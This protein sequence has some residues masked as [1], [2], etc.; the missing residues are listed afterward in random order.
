MDETTR[1]AEFEQYYERLVRYLVQKFQFTQDEA[2]DIAQDV[3]V[4][5]LATSRERE[6]ASPWLLLKTMAH[7]VAVNTVRSRVVHRRSEINDSPPYQ[8]L[9]DL[10]LRDFWTGAAPPSP[11][12]AA[13][14]SERAAQLR[15]AIAQLPTRARDAVLLWLEGLSHAEIAHKLNLRTGTVVSHLVT[16]KRQL[17]QRFATADT[18]ISPM[19]KFERDAL[20]GSLVDDDEVNVTVRRAVEAELDTVL[21]KLRLILESELHLLREMQSFKR[22]LHSAGE[23]ARKFHRSSL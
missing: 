13:L 16:A 8:H 6:V 3:F 4:Q 10:P 23:W 19:D 20:A 14:A 1:H 22:E 12:S 17:R 9:A 2:R 15:E 11:D 21:K 18:A 5:L 7:N